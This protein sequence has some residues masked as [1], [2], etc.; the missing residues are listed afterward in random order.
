[1]L[2]IFRLLRIVPNIKSLSL[3][4]ETLIK[5]LKHLRPFGGIIVASYYVFAILGMMLFNNS[6]SPSAV[7]AKE[8]RELTGK[9]GSFDQLQ[10]YANNF[11]DFGA[12]LVVLW[13]LMVVNNWHVFLKEYAKVVSRW[14]QLYFV[15][16][17]LISV[18]LIINL[19]VALILE[20]FISQ[21]EMK[22]Q[23]IR[24]NDG[25][26][27]LEAEVT[28]SH[29]GSRFHQLFSTNLVEPTEEELVNELS[30]HHHYIFDV[31]GPGETS[32]ERSFQSL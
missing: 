30:S 15:A 8:T 27:S 17:Y 31:Q 29:V 19:F 1:M 25:T 3:I 26:G 2:I 32:D 11:D 14:S 10:Y 28:T 22:Q 6:T 7:G 18:I 20:A 24:Q 5:L 23:R 21:W 9:C 12:A 16:W 13:D 4:V